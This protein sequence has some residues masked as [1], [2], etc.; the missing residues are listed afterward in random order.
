[1]AEDKKSQGNPYRTI[2]ILLI[3]IVAGTLPF[4]YIPSRQ[5]VFPK[6][7][8]TFSNTFITQADIDRLIER[9]NSSFFDALAM[10]D[11]PLSRKLIEKG[12]IGTGDRPSDEDEYSEE[13]DENEFSTEEEDEIEDLE[14][15]EPLDY[16]NRN[17]RAKF[18]EW[19]QYLID[20][21][22]FGC[23]STSD[24]EEKLEKLK[25]FQAGQGEYEDLDLTGMHVYNPRYVSFQFNNDGMDDYII[26]YELGNCNMGNAWTKDFVFLISDGS[27]GYTINQALATGIKSQFLEYANQFSEWDGHVHME[28][29]YIEAMGLSIANAS[30]GVISGDFALSGA[31]GSKWPSIEGTFKYDAV[32]GKLT[33]IK[34]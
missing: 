6:E 31:S 16:L 4:H 2:V 7:H 19:E 21:S 13:Y 32:D 17:A 28:N 26:I 3:V 15:G 18:S 27:S 11:D 33:L 29:G 23:I 14:P 22:I 9:H 5:M 34:D 24:C 20:N 10:M 12:V 1:M 8:L 25:K 30:S